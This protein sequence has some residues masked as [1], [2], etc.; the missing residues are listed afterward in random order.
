M[1]GGYIAAELGYF[2]GTL[3]TNITIIGREDELLPNEDVDVREAVTEAF[4]ERYTVHT[5]Y[6]ATQV[7]SK[8]GTITATGENKGCEEIEATEHA[9]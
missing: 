2:Y 5:G 1:G 3:G 9:E 8:N 7:E 6:S 4:N